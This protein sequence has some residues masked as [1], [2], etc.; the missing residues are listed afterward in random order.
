MKI[1][2]LSFLILNSSFL[3]SANAGSATWNL[4]P[5]N[6]NWGTASNWTPAT[7]PNGS[8]DVATFD[9][10]DTTDINLDLPVTLDSMAFA[11]SANPCTFTTSATTLTIS[12]VGILTNSG[13]TQSFVAN[14]SANRL[15]G[16]FAFLNTATAGDAHFTITGAISPSGQGATILF[17]DNSTAENAVVETF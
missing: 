8:A 9:L 16:G 17:R 15:V 13:V 12:G 5:T 10:S 2:L 4:S 3:L 11:S 14:G 6:H 7:V 1:A